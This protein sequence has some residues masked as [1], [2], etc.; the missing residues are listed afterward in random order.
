MLIGERML[1]TSAE[2]AGRRMTIALDDHVAGLVEVGV[3]DCLKNPPTLVAKRLFFRQPR[4]LTVA[5]ER[6]KPSEA[7]RLTV[8]DDKG[9][10]VSAAVSMAAFTR[11][12]AD[13]S[14][15][16]S[17]R[18]GLLR[19]MLLAGD[20]SQASTL[21]EYVLPQDHAESAAQS[22]ELALGC[23]GS[24]A[25]PAEKKNT[26]KPD[27]APV[28]VDNLNEL[29]DQYEATLSE[30]RAQRT[31]VI[32]ALVMLSF[33]GG[34]GLALLVTM[35]ALLRIVRGSQ[36]WLPIVGAMLCCV[37]VTTVSNDPSRM[38]PVEVAAVG[39]ASHASQPPVAAQAAPTATPAADGQLQRLAEKLAGFEGEAEALKADRFPIAQYTP[40]KASESMS[41]VERGQPAAW[42][43]LL[44]ADREG[45][46]TVPGITAS[47]AKSLRLEIEAHNGGQLESC[48]LQP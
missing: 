37:V 39:F 32:N 15:S 9:Q 21:A 28:I 13:A 30:Y 48:E 6:F 25:P 22:L 40:T 46:V 19:K 18:S 27:A 45:H 38:K 43:P 23:Q 26:V 3:Y 20:V 31:Q 4:R 44:I 34:L 7:L 35:L 2:K 36:L 41:S 16:S 33:F 14:P 10:P 1:L 42:Y 12:K 29:R 24:P 47:P 11:A 8:R 17:P 5:A